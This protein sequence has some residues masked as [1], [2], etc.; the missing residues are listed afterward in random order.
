LHPVEWNIGEAAG[1][2][3]A[4]VREKKVQ[5]REVREKSGLLDEFQQRLRGLGVETHWPKGPF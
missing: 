3:V 4:F 2:L 1:A 5:P